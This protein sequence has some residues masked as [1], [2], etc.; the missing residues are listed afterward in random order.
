MVGEI[1]FV[2]SAPPSATV[3]AVSAATVLEIPK[4]AIEEKANDDHGFGFR[5]YRA[6]ALFL[7]DRLRISQQQRRNMS[8]A[9]SL[10]DDNMQFDELDEK[11]LDTLSLAGDRFDRLL[12]ILAAG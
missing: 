1:G 8:Q 11:L 10:A 6:I 12:R 9:A 2:D 7:A 5:F 3:T 4:A